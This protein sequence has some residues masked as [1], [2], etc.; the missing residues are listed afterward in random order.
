MATE[1][2]MIRDGA[3]CA[4]AADLSTSQY[5]AVK[6]TAARAV[7]LANTGGEVAY[8]ILQNKPTLGQPADVCFLG[9]T[10]AAAGAAFAA[11]AQL[12]TD[13]T[14]RMITRTSAN[15]CVALAIEAATVAGQLITV[16]IGPNGGDT[17]A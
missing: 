11:G 1:G 2:P 8:G 13:A 9:V 12:M 6:I 15:H 7:N 17:V 4:A 10:K 16:V 3:Q 5:Y 14:G